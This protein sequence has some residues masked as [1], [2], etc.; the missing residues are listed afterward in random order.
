MLKHYFSHQQY[1]MKGF[2]YYS[3]ILSIFKDI[4]QVKEYL[5]EQL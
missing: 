4:F 5:E 3:K 1:T 2:V